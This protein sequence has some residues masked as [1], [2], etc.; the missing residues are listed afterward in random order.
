MGQQLFVFKNNY[1]FTGVNHVER[2]VSGRREV[3]YPTRTLRE[4]GTATEISRKQPLP[5]EVG[6]FF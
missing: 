4:G 3:T 6:S 1:N 2:N 5:G